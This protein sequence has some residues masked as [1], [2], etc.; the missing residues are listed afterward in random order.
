VTDGLEYQYCWS[1]AVSSADPNTLLLTASH[2][3]YGAHYKESARSFVYRRS[4]DDAWQQI[5]DGLPT[6]QGSRI[7]VVAASHLEPG[8]FYCST[9]GGVYRS[10]DNGVRW[11]ELKVQWKSSTLTEHAIDMAIA[12]SGTSVD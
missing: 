7:G 10:K 5:C 3:A 8:I 12:E 11:Q 6:P 1:I 4:G 9:E 2:S